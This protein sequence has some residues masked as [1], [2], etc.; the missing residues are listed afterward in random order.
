MV[1]ATPGA[2]ATPQLWILGS[3]LYCA[4]LAAILGLHGAVA[5]QTAGAVRIWASL[6]K[7]EPSEITADVQVAQVKA[8]LGPDVRELQLDELKG[9]VGWKQTADGFEVTTSKL[10][11]SANA[12]TLQPM[13]LIFKFRRA[14]GNKA[15][16]G[17]L[18]IGC[19]AAYVPFTYRDAGKIVGYDVELAEIFCK[20][21]GVKPNFIDTA[22]A[23]VIEPM[24]A[25][26]SNPFPIDHGRPSFFMSFCKSRRVMSRPT[27]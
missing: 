1:S 10:G 14:V 19:E 26:W 25:E 15:P 16:R 9:R 24:G 18:Q 12:L 23:G 8:R 22:W 3:S 17:E 7:G 21:L 13:D 4:Q 5:V 11:M 6:D 2:G 27:A 20:T